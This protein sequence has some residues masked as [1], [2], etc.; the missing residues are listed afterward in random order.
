MRQISSSPCYHTCL[1]PSPPIS[2]LS[3]PIS[4]ISPGYYT[5]LLRYQHEDFAGAAAACDAALRSGACDG[6]AASRYGEIWGRYGAVWRVRRVS[7]L[8]IWGD[9]G[10]IWGDMGRG[11]LT[12]AEHTA[13]PRTRLQPAVSEPCPQRSN[14]G[15]RSVYL[16]VYS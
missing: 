9:M 14:T 8:Q 4:P 2:P 3:P 1:L 12:R 7:R 11:G 16:K 13:T 6:S 5:C 15:T 10:E